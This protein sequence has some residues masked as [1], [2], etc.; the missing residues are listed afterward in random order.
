MDVGFIGLG[1]MGRPMA[2]RLIE[3][4]HRVK[5]WNRTASAGDALKAKGATIAADPSGVVDADV[6]ITMLAD[7][8]SVDATWLAS[9]LAAKM[10]RGAVHANMASTSVDIAKRLGAAHAAA[11]GRYVSAPVFG[12]PAVAAQ[13]QL[14]VIAAGPADALAT[15]EPLFKAMSKQIFVVGDE[16]GRANAVKIAR[17]FLISTVI[18]S[19]AE[20]FAITERC[21]VPRAKFLEILANSSLG[22]PAIKNY[23]K[24]MVDRAYEPAA[25]NMKLGLK[26]VELALSTA[27][28]VGLPLPS[29]EVVKKNFLEAIAAGD[30]EKDWAA[31]AERIGAAKL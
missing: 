23:G 24:L 11:G 1:Q 9:G 17:N 30:G 5:A 16:P 15:V 10:R 6:V 4:G 18:E 31:I 2:M 25:F 19:L 28:S 12:R 14:D 3:A 20:A 13:G 21:G 8:A 27:A 22:S 7:D 29:G 26:D